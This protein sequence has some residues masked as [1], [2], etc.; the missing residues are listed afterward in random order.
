MNRKLPFNMKKVISVIVALTFVISMFSCMSGISAFAIG[1]HVHKICVNSDIEDQSSYGD[2]E[3]TAWESA[4]SLPTSAGNYYLTQ[5]VTLTAQPSIKA[6][7]T[8]CLN[9]HTVTQSIT[10]GDAGRAALIGYQATAAL[11]ICDCS[12][13][14]TGTIKRTTTNFTGTSGLFLISGGGV[15]SD[16][17]AYEGG[18]LNLYSGTLDGSQIVASNNTGAVVGVNNKFNMYG[19]TII[20]GTATGNGSETSVKGFGGSV[21]VSSTGTVDMYGGTITGGTAAQGGNIYIT[22]NDTASGGIFNMHGGLIENGNATGAVKIYAGTDGDIEYSDNAYGGNVYIVSGGQFNMTGGTVTDGLS[23]TINDL[24]EALGGNIYLSA[25]SSAKKTALNVQGGTISAGTSSNGG[26]IAL[27]NT[28][29]A[30][31]NLTGGIVEDGKAVKIVNNGEYPYGTSSTN[32]WGGQGG[33][34]YSYSRINISGTAVIRNG[35]APGSFGGGNI[36]IRSANGYLKMTGGTISGGTAQ[37][38]PTASSVNVYDNDATTFEMTGGT[39]T[40]GSVRL[41]KGVLSLSGTAKIS[42]SGA[43][44]YLASGNTLTVGALDEAASVAVSMQTVGTFAAGAAQYINCF[45]AGETGYRVVASGADLALEVTQHK[46]AIAVNTDA[47]A[48]DNLTDAS[49]TEV[50]FEEWTSTTSLP[51]GSAYAGKSYYLAN[52]V[53]ISGQQSFGYFSISEDLLNNLCLNGHT[54]TYVASS[55][56][57]AISLHHTVAT[58]GDYKCTLNIC[59]CSRS[60]AGKI[61]TTEITKSTTGTLIWVREVCSELN[62]YS[63]TIDATNIQ[64]NNGAYYTGAVYTNGVFNM[65]GGKIL[66]GTASNGAAVFVAKANDGA[67]NMYGGEIVGGT[68]MGTQAATHGMGGA[69][70]VSANT[71]ANISGGTITGGTATSLSSDGGLGGAVYSAGTLTISDDAEIIGGTAVHASIGSGYG[72][73]GS[74]YIAG[75]TSAMTGGTITGGTAR[76]GAALAVGYGS[77]LTFTMSGGTVN[78]GQAYNG[79]AVSVW[80]KATFNFEGGVIDGRTGEAQNCGGAIYAIS[81]NATVSTLNLKSG[82]IYGGT[83]QNGGAVYLYARTSTTTDGEISYNRTVMNLLGADIIGG[84][85]RNG[86]AVYNAGATLNMTS[87]T[88]QDG[89]ADDGGNQGGSTEVHVVQGSGGNFYGAENSVTTITGGTVKDGIA[90]GIGGN[91]YNKGTLTISNATVS[92]GEAKAFY[93]SAGNQ[94]GGHGGNIYTGSTNGSIVNINGGAVIEN[95]VAK[96]GGNISESSVYSKIIM[97]GGTVKNGWGELEG[98]GNIYIFNAPAATFEISGGTVTTNAVAPTGYSGGGIRIINGT[99]KVSGSAN[100]S[101]ILTSGK[102]TADSMTITITELA[103]TASIGVAIINNGY[104]EV[105]SMDADYLNKITVREGV[106]KSYTG[107]YLVLNNQSAVE[108]AENVESI[109]TVDVKNHQ[110]FTQMSD[111]AA[112]LITE[113]IS[114]KLAEAN[115]YKKM[116]TVKV[117][118]GGI[119]EGKQL[120]IFASSVDA[121]EPYSKVSVLITINGVE[122]TIDLVNVYKNIYNG[123]E[124]VVSVDDDW[125]TKTQWVYAVALTVSEASRGRVAEVKAMLTLNDG[126]QVIGDTMEVEIDNYLPSV[127]G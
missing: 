30:E 125:S 57:R 108:E 72:M 25:G 105:A 54:I 99:L 120:I 122:K 69:V 46:H 6:D 68:A 87:G 70:Y 56:D 1:E 47:D 101:E 61:T 121:L 10:G 36:A 14:K 75:G 103:D 115:E 28:G 97:T 109:D 33:N 51:T 77:A 89:I 21:Y 96:M 55:G 73:G 104:G 34:I 59:D 44:I 74:V 93:N 52:D 107:G 71:T 13:Q 24:R 7:V 66:G 53:T 38:V 98:S 17:T 29:Y 45:T 58:Q 27:A 22:S 41:A 5:D 16:G 86:G 19:G 127:N 18:T 64:N 112:S 82:T 42:E 4:T 76:T 49:K 95:G 116:I 8:I 48:L 113:D 111:E 102:Y 83:A 78:A 92:G 114:D 81:D 35:S 67:F 123:S 88:I 117:Y 11:S 9:G 2:I 12:A 50:V 60:M 94:E 90:Y 62:L 118:N 126:T 80:T 124:I 39:V 3:F 110:S 26:N 100:V 79:A 106:V 37:S 40:G 43:G 31:V 15:L 85:A 20:G 119:Y 23:K 32:G 91:I 84:T 65:Y 63:G